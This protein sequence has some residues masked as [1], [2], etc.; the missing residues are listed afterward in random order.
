MDAQR[1]G[2]GDDARLAHV[3]RFGGRLGVLGYDV[4]NGSRAWKLSLE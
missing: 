4:S 2:R 3:V 1:S